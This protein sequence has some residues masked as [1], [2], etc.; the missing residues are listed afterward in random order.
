MRSRR[1]R[2]PR[3]PTNAFVSVT[4]RPC[5]GCR[6]AIKD[7]VKLAGHST[8][9]G[10]GG[11]YRPATEDA[12]VVRRL[13]A[14]GAIVIGK[15]HAPEVGQWPFTESPTFG[16]THNPWST[17]H[18]PGGSS[19]GAAAAVAAGLVPAAIGSDGAGSIRIP[20]AWT[21]LVGL[22]P[23][24]GR[25]STLPDAEAFNGLTCFGPLTHSVADTALLLHAVSGNREGDLHRLPQGEWR[26]RR[27]PV[28]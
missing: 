10:C 15:T 18:T 7:D 4:A 20:A 2:K 11:S 26:E 12:E 6:S 25:I 24:R 13:R 16:A 23:Q 3:P 17:E 21:G 14:A 19:G 27:P 5:W 22:K 8:P 1:C 9:F 28:G